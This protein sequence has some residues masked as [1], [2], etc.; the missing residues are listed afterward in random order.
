MRTPKP[1]AFGRGVWFSARFLLN[2][3]YMKFSREQ[4]I[5]SAVVVALLLAAG[6][7]VYL[8]KNQDPYEGLVTYIEVQADDAT[9]A[10]AGQRIAT[11]QA[12]I[13]AAKD[14]GESVMPDF[15]NS[16]ASDALL[17][18]DLILVR[19]S[20]ESSLALNSL[21]SS[22]WSSYAYALFLMQD[23]EDAKTAY[24]RTL[25]LTPLET[26]Y[27]ALIDLLEEQFPEEKEEVK[28]LY[29]DAVEQIGQKMFNMLGL[30]N[31][32]ADA[33]N[34]DKAKDHFK[35]AEDLAASEEIRTQV[36][37]EKHAALAACRELNSTG[38]KR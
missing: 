13:Q 30:G 24:Y 10:L 1:P 29:E 34:C 2:S 14:A 38:E 36:E 6:I 18:G 28:A 27:R 20:L 19:E 23:Y 26:D 11:A 32:Y 12:A 5:F 33:G 31:W 3:W 35:V 8:W 4:V 22:V 9:R 7:G 15:Y 25:E 16:I 21:D 37:E 17:L